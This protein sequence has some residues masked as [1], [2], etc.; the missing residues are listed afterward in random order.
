MH[1][2]AFAL[3]IG[4]CHIPGI[5]AVDVDGW[6][7]G[8][9]PERLPPCAFFVEDVTVAGDT[10]TVASEVE[11]NAT[12]RTRL[13]RDMPGATLPAMIRSPHKTQG[14]APPLRHFVDRR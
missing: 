9:G 3:P 6:L 4:W 10:T 11:L 2:V 8:Q 5:A 12:F 1:A 13:I 14:L 7:F